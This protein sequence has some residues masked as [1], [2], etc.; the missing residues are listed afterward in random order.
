MESS[1]QSPMAEPAPAEETG[2]YTCNLC[3]T[4]VSK[5]GFSKKQLKAGKKSNF[6]EMTCMACEAPTAAAAGGEPTEQDSDNSPPTVFTPEGPYICAGP[7]TIK[8]SSTLCRGMCITAV[9]QRTRSFGRTVIIVQ[10]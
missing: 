6:S 4:D 2:M 10:T 9:C 1:R 7:I 5:S 8:L 3:N